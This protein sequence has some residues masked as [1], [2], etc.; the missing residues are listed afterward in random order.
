MLAGF[1]SKATA[2]YEQGV[3]AARQATEFDP[4]FAMAY[5]N[6]A[7]N[8]AYLG[9]FDEAENIL[10]RAAGRGLE[11]DEFLML[12]HDIAFLKTDAASMARTAAR[13]RDR[14]GAETWVAYK[15]SAALA[16]S[17]RLRQARVFTQRAIDQGIQAGQPE[18]A[19]LWLAGESLREA[20]FGQRASSEKGC[21]RR[22][23]AFQQLRSG[24]WR[25]FG[26]GHRRRFSPS[27]ALQ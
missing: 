13:A 14:S 1:P 10:R 22:S 21:E 20:W 12:Q 23:Q 8:N 18:R 17:G 26:V 7:V 4:D 5:Y 6:L 27:S 24:V 9:R 2:R 3:A 19:A 16:Y 15:E 11:I 25:G